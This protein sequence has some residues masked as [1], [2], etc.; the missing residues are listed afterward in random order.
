[1]DH[2]DTKSDSVNKA[3]LRCVRTIQPRR[4][5]TEADKVLNDPV[6]LFEYIMKITSPSLERRVVSSLCCRIG[7]YFVIHNI[8]PRRRL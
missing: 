6:G 4:T 7:H 5:V 2:F 1:M 8:R 3:R